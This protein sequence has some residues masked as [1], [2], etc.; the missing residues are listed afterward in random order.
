MRK[1]L[2]A[3]LFVLAAPTIFASGPI[4]FSYFGRPIK[5]ACIALFN[6]TLE[7]TPYVRTINLRMCQSG[8]SFSQDTHKDYRGYRFFYKNN[9]DIEDGAYFYKLIGKTANSIY[10]LHTYNNP[11]GHGL[12]DM[13]LF[14]RMI[15]GKV[16]VY[17]SSSHAAMEPATFLTLQS[18]LMGG[19][20]CTGGI[21]SA[22]VRGNKVIVW[23]YP[24]K[25]SVN[26]CRGA[27][28]FVLDLSKF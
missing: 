6:S 2:L 26:Q 17:D 19:D 11:R 15:K 14:M 23:Q 13:L 16:A 24:K 25:N 27:K 9:R 28:E 22:K 7:N 8:R 20:R 21:K 18:Y 3:M 5:P 4:K 10:V 1:M 12:Y